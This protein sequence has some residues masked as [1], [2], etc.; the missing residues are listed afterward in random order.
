M[1]RYLMKTSRW[2]S[3][4]VLLVWAI[5]STIAFFQP[6]PQLFSA[7][8][9]LLLCLGFAVFLTDRYKFSEERRLWDH[10]IETQL[11]MTWRYLQ[12]LRHPDSGPAQ[13]LTIDEMEGKLTD[14]FEAM[15]EAKRREV[16]LETY[17]LE[18]MLSIIG[19]LQWGFGVLFLE[20]V[21]G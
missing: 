9:S 7:M 2:V 16:S 6:W 11:R 10:E 1:L 15:I 8:G 18:I 20:L 21:W 17:R 19:T 12:R 14:S 4:L 13:P 5:T 3:L